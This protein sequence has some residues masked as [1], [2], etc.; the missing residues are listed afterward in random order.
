M[1][2]QQSMH[3][4]KKTWVILIENVS[5]DLVLDVS[6]A[7]ILSLQ[8]NSNSTFL[9]SGTGTV[10]IYL[11]NKSQSHPRSKA[12]FESY[13]FSN[14]TI[15][16][17]NLTIFQQDFSFQVCYIISHF[18]FQRHALYFSAFIFFVNSYS[19]PFNLFMFQVA[20]IHMLWLAMRLVNE[21]F[22]ILTFQEVRED[23]NLVTLV[24]Y[25]YSI[26]C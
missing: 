2:S 22:N 11:L 16:T 4:I 19:L 21:N 25:T 20:V 23:V 1:D 14:Y 6:S 10:F 13:Y 8:N 15:Y 26:S 9:L 18:H 5:W 17:P 12:Q 24:S 3:G 7:F